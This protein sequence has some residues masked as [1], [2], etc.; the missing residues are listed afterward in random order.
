VGPAVAAGR[1]RG[2]PFVEK[3]RERERRESETEKDEEE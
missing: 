3:R 2:G 1:A